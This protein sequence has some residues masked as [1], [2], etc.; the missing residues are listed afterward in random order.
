M[1]YIAWSPS[2]AVFRV[3]A[4]CLAEKPTNSPIPFVAMLGVQLVQLVALGLGL[5]ALELGG[6]A[7]GLEKVAL[8]LGCGALGFG[9][10]AQPPGLVAIGLGPL[11]AGGRL[12]PRLCVRS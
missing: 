5:G 1:A 11:A 4:L 7:L 12:K 2:A 9:R 8:G 10:A 6:K 3:A